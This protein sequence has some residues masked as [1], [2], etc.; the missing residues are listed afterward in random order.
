MTDIY[1]KMLI[2][3]EYRMSLLGLNEGCISAFHELHQIP[4][5]DACKPHALSEYP[6]FQTMVNHLQENGEIQRLVFAIIVHQGENGCLISY[7]YVNSVEAEWQLQRT[8]AA[9]G[10]AM[11][12]TVNERH[13]ELS[14]FGAI[15][16][17]VENGIAKRIG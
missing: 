15:C 9:N 3:A 17:S 4:V 12:Y 7:L 2:E 6:T 16:I 13:P 5:F 14:E 8:D 11:T 1:R 10:I